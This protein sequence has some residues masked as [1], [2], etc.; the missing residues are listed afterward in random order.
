[1]DN[2][3]NANIEDFSGVKWYIK[4]RRAGFLSSFLFLFAILA[5][6]VLMAL[7]IGVSPSVTFSDIAALVI[8]IFVFGLFTVSQLMS[9]L[10]TFKW[11]VD[12]YWYGT[13]TDMHRIKSSKGKTKG[14]I[15]IA[16]VGNGKQLDGRCLATT[17]Q[18]AE[19]G[20]QVLLFSLGTDKI[21]CVHP[22]M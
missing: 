9:Y 5:V 20:Q 8:F 17:Y 19:V 2:Y 16:D 18:Q 11:K 3:T 22:E 14:Y 7:A 15:I 12:R 21:Y 4:K 6:F 13:I 10:N 1:M